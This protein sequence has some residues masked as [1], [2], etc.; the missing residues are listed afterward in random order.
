M[1]IGIDVGST[2]IKIVFLEPG[3]PGKILWKTVVPTKPGQ[4]SLVN[5]LVEQGLLA[6]SAH[7][8]DIEKVS[9]TGYGRNLIES[10]TQ[11]IDEISANAAGIHSLTRGRCR[12]LINIGG[13]DVK[14]IR[15]SDRGQVLDFR[16]ND[17]CAAG[18]GRFFEIAATILDTPL[19]DF[20]AP[21]TV[22]AVSINSTCAVFAESEIV[23]LLAKGIDKR[24]I[25]KGINNAVAKRIANLA[26]NGLLEEEVYVDGGPAKNLGLIQSLEDALLCDI[27]VTREPQFTVALGSLLAD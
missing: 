4:A 27:K 7:K 22:E 10:K 17:K 13:Q 23:S 8:S 25:I 21:E 11:V 1:K 20:S 2:G 19:E 18:T 9:V 6:C 12:T 3:A 16:M 5:G 26:G 24:S 15:L 14:I